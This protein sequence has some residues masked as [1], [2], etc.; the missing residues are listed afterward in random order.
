MARVHVTLKEKKVVSFG[1]SVKGKKNNNYQDFSPCPTLL[2]DRCFATMN[3]PA[4]PDVHQWAGNDWQATEDYT[5]AYLCRQKHPSR[6][7]SGSYLHSWWNNQRS[8]AG[9]SINTDQL[10]LRETALCLERKQTLHCWHKS[11]QLIWQRGHLGSKKT[12]V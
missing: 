3:S 7:K 8:P 12:A 1:K 5:R 2:R 9:Q 6:R 11:S 10:M 4:G